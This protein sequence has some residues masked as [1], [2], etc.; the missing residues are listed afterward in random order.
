MVARL[1][2]RFEIGGKRYV[3]DPETCFCFEC[4]EISWD[5][6]E[7][8]PEAPV[9]RVFHL[10]KDKHPLK[11]LEEV[12]GE[13]EW[14]RGSKSI[15]SPPK[16]EQQQKAFEIERG[17]RRLEIGVGE[18]ADTVSA[19]A[20]RGGWFKKPQRTETTIESAIATRIR[21]CTALLL[22]RGVSNAPLRLDVSWESAITR[23]DEVS[24]A[25]RDA[26]G[27]A[28]M[29]GKTVHI[30]LCVKVDAVD[31][32]G[33]AAVAYS[34]VCTQAEQ[35]EAAH[36]VL[37]A[38]RSGSKAIAK[39]FGALP[40]GASGEV[41][42]VPRGAAFTD[43]VKTLHGAGFTTIELDLVTLYATK[44]PAEAAQAVRDCGEFYAAALLKGDYFRLEPIASIFHRIYLGMPVRRTDPAGL[45]LL[46]VDASGG[47]YP[48]RAFAG[49]AEHLIGSV[50]E[51]RLDAAKF[52]RYEDIGSV[53]TA[54]CFSCWARNLCGGGTAAVHEARTGDYRTPDPAWCDAQ[55]GWL[56]A[57]IATFNQ[58]SGAG[59]NF[60]RVYGQ[61][62]KPTKL[63][64]FTMVKAAF[65]M[66]I[67]L[68]PLGEADAELLTKWQNFNDAAYFT[69]NET[70]LLMATKYDREM[71]AL[72]PK[73]YE[74]EFLLLRKS[75]APL[76]LLRLRPLNTPGTAMAWVYLRDAADYADESV[77]KSF[78]FLLGEAGKQ[79][80]INHLLIPT[81][82]FDT[83]LA[84]F[85]A[86]TGF[87]ATGAQREA[88]YLR[89]EYHDVSWHAA[90]LEK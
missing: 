75:G 55:R 14:L 10:L 6:L 51:E 36:D 25:L 33:G 22:A 79:Q 38:A 80:G 62:G 83:G 19:P 40:D 42:L 89:G 49:K 28:A 9:N 7:H 85:L 66:N 27:L 15:L 43:A 4:D 34:V 29:A 74:F 8:F 70:G 39:A 13:L 31:A 46:H 50:D 21:R 56:E 45:S 60:A 71:D 72:Y 24:A 54:A 5:V 73:G 61:L 20:P 88:L 53:T 86:A 3:I 57:A 35:L 18:R 16:L 37:Q 87:A 77:R 67:G 64:L 76:G 59:V 2:H 65:Q 68:R 11:E 26:F 30:A 90:V 84:D 58:L 12:V 44:A 63:S 1:L 32:L 23:F 17:L 82:P 41:L 81:G 47:I 78:R 48:A 52:A 69:F